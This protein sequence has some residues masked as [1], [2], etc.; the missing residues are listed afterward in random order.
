MRE[1]IARYCYYCGRPL[2]EGVI[3]IFGKAYALFHLQCYNTW[4]EEKKDEDTVRRTGT[5]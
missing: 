5:V 3:I 2:Q 1:P 4:R